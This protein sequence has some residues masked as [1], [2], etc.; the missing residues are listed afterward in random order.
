MGG[1]YWFGTERGRPPCLLRMLGF[2]IHPE[3]LSKQTGSKNIDA[4][5]KTP[6]VFFSY[7]SSCQF[8]QWEIRIGPTNI[9]LKKSP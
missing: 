9:P 5:P 7:C 1:W 2:L 4:W 6:V 8:C 3:K